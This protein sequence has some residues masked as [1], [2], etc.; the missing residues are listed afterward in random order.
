MAREK[1]QLATLEQKQEIK[2]M[3]NNLLNRLNGNGFINDSYSN[4][5]LNQG[6]GSSSPMQATNY[7]SNNSLTWDMNRIMQVEREQPLYRKILN[8]K[9]SMSLAK[10]DIDC[11]EM[12]STQIKQIKNK[13]DDIYK[14]LYSM[15]YQGEAFGGG[16]CLVC[17]RGQMSQSELIKP[18][19][20]DTIQPNSF[21]GLK[22]LERWFSCN[23]TGIR[24]ENVGG[25]DGID[26][27]ELIGQPLY[28]QVRIGGKGTK[29]YKVHRTRLLLYNTGHL[30]NL[31]KQIE[32]YWG[33][34]SLERI[35]DSLN[36]YNTV[37]HAIVNMFLIS[38]TRVIKMEDI[39]TDASQLSV[40]AYEAI[41]NK[42]TLI[43]KALN[44]S[45]ILFL[46][47]GDTF[48]YEN[49]TMSNVS[50]VIKT[51]RLDLCSSAEVSM[52]YMFDDGV[53]DMQ[54]TENAHASIKTVQRLFIKD[55]YKTLIKCIY[56][57]LF[58]GKI[59]DFE[60]EFRKIREISDKD[61]ADV[62][63]KMVSAL[64]EVY[65]AN[66]MD[67]ETLIHSLSEILQNN[68]DIF[69]NYNDEFIEKR[70]KE[71]YND[72]QIA[73]A[74]ALNGGK[75]KNNNEIAKENFGGNNNEK[76][77]TPKVK[78]EEGSDK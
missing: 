4:L 67:K 72:D 74:R 50:E 12:T 77:A 27:P 56:K 59:P 69:S 61:T 71:T 38:A 1:I 22:S 15:I 29:T 14:S 32:Q 73:L 6:F 76:K 24:V 45:N 40:M 20:Y 68:A 53:N 47:S 5:P 65:K 10:I 44:Y 34:S 35:W 75:D 58:G 9:A 39:D 57:S 41:K 63:S 31:Q 55:Y 28:Y 60:I 62:F 2:N 8:Y 36:R 25:S 7:I 16:A 48:Q 21:L 42:L 3:Y 37:M 17:I 26:D 23:P 78:I 46:G 64:V 51:V 19:N 11:K 43:S 30:S 18:L 52:S 66:G 70:G 33:A 13:L 49:V 54:T